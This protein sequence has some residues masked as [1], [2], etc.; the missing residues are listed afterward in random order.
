MSW[1]N[2]TNTHNIPLREGRVVHIE[3]REIAL[4]NLADGFAAIENKCPHSGAPLCDGIVSGEAVVCPLHGWRISLKTGQVLRGDLNA[5]PVQVYG[6]AVERG[7][8]MVEIPDFEETRRV[9]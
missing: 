3:D 2:I 6:T 8:L 7:R 4:F 9:A 5:A 1:I